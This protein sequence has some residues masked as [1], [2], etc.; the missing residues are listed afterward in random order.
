MIYVH[1][2]GSPEYRKLER[3][4]LGLGASKFGIS[5][6]GN[7][8]YFVVYK[9]RTIHFSDRRYEDWTFHGDPVRRANYR[10][11]HSKIL[12]KDRTPAYKNKNQAAYWSYWILW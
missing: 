5:T 2:S 6:K 7:Y 9:N 4:A 10:A 8:K 12:L 3:A 11:R 1:K